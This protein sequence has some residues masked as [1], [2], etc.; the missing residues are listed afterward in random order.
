M[1]IEQNFIERFRALTQYDP[2]SWQQRLFNEF[3]SKGEI[4]AAIDIPTG[5][6]KTAVMALWLIAR[7]QGGICRDAWFM[8]VFAG[9]LLSLVS[10]APV[11]AKPASR[12]VFVQRSQIAGF[13]YYD[14]PH[15][16]AHVEGRC[17]LTLQREPYNPY[18]RHAV[19]VYWQGHKVGYIPRG[20]NRVIAKLLDR[21]ETLETVF[22]GH[23]DGRGWWTWMVDVE[24]VV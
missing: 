2:T 22:A 14:G 21:G 19:A 5:L 23:L 1:T 6:G 24:V 20:E 13:Q 3:F 16:T 10:L 18:D 9:P 8:V 12:H 7:S 15:V 11:E 4:P 17:A